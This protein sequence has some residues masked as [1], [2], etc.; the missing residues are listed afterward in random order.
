M[1]AEEFREPTNAERAARIDST[2]VSPGKG[3]VMKSMVAAVSHS[4]ALLVAAVAGLLAAVI[5]IITFASII[6]MIQGG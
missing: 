4:P 6:S 2:Y 5:I 3:E 1:E